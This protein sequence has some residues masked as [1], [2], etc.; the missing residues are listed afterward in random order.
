MATAST[1]GSASRGRKLLCRVGLG[2][3]GELRH[4]LVG[5][6]GVNGGQVAALQV[7]GAA[8]GA[9]DALHLVAYAG[10]LG[11]LRRLYGAA[12]VLHQE[13]VAQ[14]SLFLDIQLALVAQDAAIDQRGVFRHGDGAVVIQDRAGLQV[15]LFPAKLRRDWLNQDLPQVDQGAALTIYISGVSSVPEQ[16]LRNIPFK[17]RGRP[18]SAAWPAFQN[19]QA[20]PSQSIQRL[21]SIVPKFSAD[22]PAPIQRKGTDK[23]P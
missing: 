12:L 5:Q 3:G 21:L 13:A 14:D 4:F 18:S 16:A 2:G 19:T 6:D 17:T 22:A 7:D 1:W 8:G 15:K 11:A 23:S 9:V 10:Q 20:F